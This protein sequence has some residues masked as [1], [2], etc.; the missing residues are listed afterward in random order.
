MKDITIT[1]K[2]K[3]YK[4]REDSVTKKMIQGLGFQ[5]FMCVLA[6]CSTDEEMLGWLLRQISEDQKFILIAT[7]VLKRVNYEGYIL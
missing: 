7:G 6:I 3:D 5:D 4:L 1:I 2:G